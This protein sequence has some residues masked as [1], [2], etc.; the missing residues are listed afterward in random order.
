M[1]TEGDSEEYVGKAM[2]D[3]A[4]AARMG[5]MFETTCLRIFGEI[6]PSSF[7]H[8]LVTLVL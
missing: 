3:E 6:P 5:T 1:Q 4:S 7:G 2:K 8:I